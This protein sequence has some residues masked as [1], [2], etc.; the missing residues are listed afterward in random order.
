M[1]V[2]YVVN[3]AVSLLVG[4][5]G[6]LLGSWSS[7]RYQLVLDQR[8]KAMETMFD[9]RLNQIQKIVTRQDKTAAVETRWKKSKQADEALATE[10]TAVPAVR[11]AMHPWDPR[12]WGKD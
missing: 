9:D 2:V 10:L 11:P 7:Y 8:Q 5:L 4:V 3:F 6:G 12:L 1:D